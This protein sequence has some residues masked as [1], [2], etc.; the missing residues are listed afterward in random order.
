M[1]NTLRQDDCVD[2][3]IVRELRKKGLPDV[4]L[5]EVV[6]ED[7]IPEIRVIRPTHVVIIDAVLLG[8]PSGSAVKT[9]FETAQQPISTHMLPLCLFA[10]YLEQKVPCRVALLLVE[11]SDVGFGEGMTPETQKSSSGLAASLFSILQ[12]KKTLKLS[13]NCF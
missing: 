2:V 12:K 3:A 10:E 8:M 13:F 7:R 4:Q 6:P 1:G 5:V 11:T 9:S